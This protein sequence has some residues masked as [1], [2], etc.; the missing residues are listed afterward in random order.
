MEGLVLNDHTH[1]M[2]WSQPGCF[3]QQAETGRAQDARGTDH[4]VPK[5][6]GRW[7]VLRWDLTHRGLREPTQDAWTVGVGHDGPRSQATA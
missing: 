1:I 5:H 6:L 7:Q 4:Q 3:R 2:G